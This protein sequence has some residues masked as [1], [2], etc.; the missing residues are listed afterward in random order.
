MSQEVK[1]LSGRFRIHEAAHIEPDESPDHGTGAEVGPESSN[2]LP[3]RF[4]QR[5]DAVFFVPNSG[6][7]EIPVRFVWARPLTGR[8][9]PVS[10]LKADKKK[11]V[12]YLQSLDL[13][14]EESR[15][16]AEREL[17]AAAVLPRI[18]RVVSTAVRFGNYYWHV[19]TNLGPAKFLITSL[20]A[21]VSRPHPDALLLKDSY[22]NC[23]EIASLSALDPLS[24]AEIDRVL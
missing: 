17:A 9:G 11:E 1:P 6:G 14:D 18:T 23:Y 19:E 8:G 7:E 21:N 16:L 10:V 22:G 20:E 2:G 15:R 12:L 3:G 13:L 24:R 5:G 4:R